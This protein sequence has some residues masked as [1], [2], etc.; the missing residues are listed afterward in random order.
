AILA[1]C[2]GSSGCGGKQA[3]ATAEPSVDEAAERSDVAGGLVIYVVVDQL[4]VA[5]LERARPALSGG[6]A[7]LLG[8]E[9]YTATARYSHSAT[10]TC[11]GHATLSTGAPPSV[12]GIVSNEWLTAEGRVYCGDLDLLL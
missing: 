9:A 5:L 2:A 3:P 12:H 1:L 10:L 7:R 6:L 4:P 11:P 8:P